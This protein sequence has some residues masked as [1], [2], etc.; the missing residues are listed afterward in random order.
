MPFPTF[1]KKADIPK[2]FEDSYQEVD[3]RFVAMVPDVAKLEDTLAK[4]RKE[5]KDAEKL[6]SEAAE[7]AADLSRQLDVEKTKG[8]D[9]DKRMGEA[10]EKWKVDTDAAV[11]KVQDKLDAAEGR[12]RTITLDDQAKS[13]F[14]K[15]GGR[16]ERADAA[17]KL[18][19][20]RLDLVDGKPVVKDEKGDVSTTTLE[21][22]WGDEVKKA[23]PELFVG[24]KAAGGGAGGSSAGAGGAGGLSI[25]DVMRNPAVA[26]EAAN[27]A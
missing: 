21:K 15:A 13:A 9:I 12:L 27:A 16:P 8:G 3:G 5:K 20:D 25:E 10:L 2:G 6:A 26:F 1:D 14:I 11:K 18:N 23:L 7:R 24:T 19:K 17:L 22:F 4:L